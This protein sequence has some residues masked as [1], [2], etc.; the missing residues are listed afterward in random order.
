MRIE[1]FISLY[2]K[3][4]TQK[5]YRAGIY[6]LLDCVY[7]KVRKGA[8]IT[9]EERE[10]YERLADQY[11]SEERDYHE[12]LLRLAAYM[13]GRPPIAA[14]ARISGAL[15]FL[16][17]NDIEF[18][19]KQRKQLSTKLPK[20]KTART[21]E[22]DI[23]TETLKKI[24]T[25][26]DLKGRAATLVLVSSG[27]RVGELFQIK[28]SDVDLDTIPPQIVIRGEGTK[29]GDTRTVFISNEAKEA[30]KEWKKI[31]GQYINSSKNRSKGLVSKDIV[32]EE[33]DKRLFPFTVENFR[34]VWENALRK[35]ELYTRDSSTGRSQIRV[36]GLR[37]FFRSQLAL[38]C[39]VD[40]VEALMGHEGYLTDA[41]RRYTRK[42][43]GEYYLKG[44]H[45]V[46][47]MGTG[48]IRE[49]QDRLQDTQAAVKGYK[50][51]ITEQAEEIAELKRK[52]EVQEQR[53]IALEKM[54]EKRRP[55]DRKMTELMKE[56]LSDTEVVEL[57]A[58]KIQAKRG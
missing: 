29:S 17:Y 51:I 33:N 23:E 20:G 21:A 50:D 44:E 25:H 7:G 49:I 34:E 55:Y 42:Q 19:D 37:K 11:F 22:K 5:V 8:S 32:N 2:P 4:N 6:V 12:D 13:N 26:M 27:M 9:K 58:Q 3:R 52:Y 31:R 47:I 54:E 45:Y 15:E 1:N 46:T 24:L 10:T 16:R 18:T 57:L 48:D 30:L 39:P 40:I 56:I 43:M 14:R 41:Y 53:L 38:S 28:L 35:A 36:H